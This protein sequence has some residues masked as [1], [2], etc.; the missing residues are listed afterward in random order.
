MRDMSKTRIVLNRKGVRELLRSQEMMNIC[1]SYGHKAV[2][3][4]GEGYEVSNHVGKNRVNS[5]V[6]TVTAEAVRENMKNNTILKAVGSS[7]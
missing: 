5:S 1:S 7:K 3:K 6:R 2:Q 4:L